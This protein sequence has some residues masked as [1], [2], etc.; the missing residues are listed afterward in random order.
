MASEVE[1]KLESHAPDDRRLQ[2]HVVDLIFLVGWIAI[3]CAT[4]KPLVNRLDLNS[5]LMLIGGIAIQMIAFLG[6]TFYYLHLRKKTLARG[7]AWLG[8]TARSRA[9]GYVAGVFL[10]LAFVSVMMIAL[11]RIV[12]SLATISPLGWAF[13]CFILPLQ[14][15]LGKGFAQFRVGHQYGVIEFFQHGV[16]VNSFHFFSWDDAKVKSWRRQPKRLVVVL[17]LPKNSEEE[18]VYDVTVSDTLRNY[19]REQGRLLDR[20]PH[21]RSMP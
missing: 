6:S 10:G 20:K 3:L 17:R 18:R 11:A 8:V 1:A 4:V 2:F 5:Q 13:Y 21:R 19:L 14:A 7:G 16:V 12:M 15:A 9:S